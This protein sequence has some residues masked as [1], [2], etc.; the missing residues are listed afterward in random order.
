MYMHNYPEQ[1]VLYNQ[2]TQMC[3]TVGDAVLRHNI[4]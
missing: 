4:C 1:Y 2:C 3:G